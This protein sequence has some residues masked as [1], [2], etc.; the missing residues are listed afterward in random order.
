MSAF[1]IIVA[2]MTAFLTV[3][4]FLAGMAA[5]IAVIGY[6]YVDWTVAFVMRPNPALPSDEEND[7]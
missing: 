2:A 3:G 6:H 5:R 4:S 1:W 7:R